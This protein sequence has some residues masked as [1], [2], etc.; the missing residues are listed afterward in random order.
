MADANAPDRYRVDKKNAIAEA[1]ADRFAE[2][3]ASLEGVGF[4]GSAILSG[5]ETAAS[6]LRE[7]IE[8]DRDA[9]KGNSPGATKDG[10]GLS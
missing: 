9:G 3:V 2:L 6:R 5:L 8:Q 4:R 1:I 7:R 10:P